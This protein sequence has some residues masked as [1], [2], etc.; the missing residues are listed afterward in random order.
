MKKGTR[1]KTQG[2]CRLGNGFLIIGAY[3]EMKA[4]PVCDAEIKIRR[5]DDED[6]IIISAKT[7]ERGFSPAIALTVSEK[8]PS[9]ISNSVIKYDFFD[10]IITKPGFYKVKVERLPIFDGV[11]SVRQCAMYA[12]NEI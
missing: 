2:G 8:Q 11:I 12:S 5:S 10:V 9:E 1:D 4:F 7:D 6:S 3:T